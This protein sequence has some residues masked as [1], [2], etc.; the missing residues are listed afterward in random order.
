[1]IKLSLIC[2]LALAAATPALASTGQLRSHQFQL[3]DMAVEYTG[4]LGKAGTLYLA[5]RDKMSGQRF[6]FAVSKSGYVRG[7]IGGRNVSFH[8]S[9]EVRG[10]AVRQIAAES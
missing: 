9:P 5:G 7:E 8:V 2:G 10:K 6:R 4:K 1:M 3:P